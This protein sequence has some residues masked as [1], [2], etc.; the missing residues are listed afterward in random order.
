MILITILLI[1][2]VF[3]MGR[4][5]SNGDGESIF[6]EIIDILFLAWLLDE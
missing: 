5:R 3:I 4:N 2:L 6:C 1:A